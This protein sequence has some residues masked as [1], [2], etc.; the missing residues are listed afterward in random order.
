MIE[1]TDLSWHC[2]IPFGGISSFRY[3]RE[4]ITKEAIEKANSQ[5]ANRT[6]YGRMDPTSIDVRSITHLVRELEIRDDGV[7]AKLESILTPAGNE[8]AMLIRLIP[9]QLLFKASC[10]SRVEGDLLIV[11]YI[12]SVDVYLSPIPVNQ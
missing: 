5:I 11:D 2:V 12:Q 7:Y 10:L 6:L 4:S 1:S 9:E 8:L 3:T